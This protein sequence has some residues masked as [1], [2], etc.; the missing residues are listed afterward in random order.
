MITYVV[1]PGDMIGVLAVKH[2]TTIRIL[3]SD[4]PFIP[5]SQKLEPGWKLSIYSPEENAKRYTDTAYERIESA[6]RLKETLATSEHMLSTPRNP[7]YYKERPILEGQIGFAKTLRETPL[8]EAQANGYLKTITVLPEGEI[9]GVYEICVLKNELMYLVD[10]YRWVTT[11]PEIVR[12]EEI[13]KYNLDGKIRIEK[14]VMAFRTMAVASAAT[15]TKETLVSPNDYSFVGSGAAPTFDK[16]NDG[17]ASTPL[18]E[19]PNYKRPVMNL[20]SVG[21]QTKTIELRLTGF[22]ASYSNTV[23]PA[24]TNGGW[25]INIR[26]H[27]LPVLNISGLL[28]ETKANDEFADFM[29][30]Y[31][32]YMASQKSGD[33]YSVGASTLYYKQT[34]YKGIVVAFSYS[35]TPEQAL[36]RRY[37]M[38][39]LVL[40]EKNL[41][42]AE[43][44]AITTVVDRKGKDEKTFRSDI[45]SMLA[46]PITGKYFVDFYE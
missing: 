13:P 39:M 3:M 21:G 35:D 44:G 25:M 17:L 23:Q 15:P 43:I 32:Q 28:L 16:A 38:Q 18:F 26:A 9:L 45:G 4:N 29:Q 1:K 8:I 30:V 5:V 33:Y 41:S 20:K 24:T 22:S 34:E 11:N 19:A 12:Y 31:H 2:K 40:K 42:A 7:V 36:H 46:N 14:E 10:G 27:G 6:H 37:N